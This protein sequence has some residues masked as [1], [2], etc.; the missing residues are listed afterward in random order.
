[1]KDTSPMNESRY[2]IIAKN[3]ITVDDTDY[4]GEH[5][6]IDMMV[7]KFR[8]IYRHPRAMIEARKRASKIINESE[9]I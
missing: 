2:K 6:T 3:T 1:M 4:K 9:D 5:T 8:D 7:E